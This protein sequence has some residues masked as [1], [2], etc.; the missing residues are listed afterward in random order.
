MAFCDL[1]LCPVCKHT[2][3]ED[4]RMYEDPD[5]CPRCGAKPDDKE[6]EDGN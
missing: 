2:W 3:L 4:D 5:R 1:R 6:K